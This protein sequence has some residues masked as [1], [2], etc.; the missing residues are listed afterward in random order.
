MRLGSNSMKHQALETIKISL[1]PDPLPTSHDSIM[2]MDLQLNR[3]LLYRVAESAVGTKCALSVTKV[4]E[5]H[6][7]EQT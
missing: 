7:R 5:T 4:S 2:E 1:L 3:E 6:Q